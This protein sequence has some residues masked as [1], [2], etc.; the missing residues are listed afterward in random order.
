MAE[1]GSSEAFETVTIRSSDG[2]TEA[3]FV[4]GANMLCASLRHRGAEL[5]DSGQGVSAYAERGTTMGIPLLYPWANRLAGAGYEAA[6]R[7]VD[8]EPAAD[9][10][11][12]DPNGLP[13]HG[14]LPGR[15]SWR[16]QAGSVADRIV[17]GLDWPVPDLQGVFPYEHQL[18]FEAHVREAE[19]EI[20]T[21]V[22]A[23]GRDR[24][25]VAYGFHPYL[26]VPGASR[27]GFRVSLGAFRRLVLDD[28]GIPT[29][30]RVPLQRR[31][32]R[33]EQRS[34]DDGLDGLAIPPE[35]AVSAG[36]L[37]ITVT[38]D[39][40]FQFAQ[41]YAPPDHDFICFEPMTAPANALRSGDGLIILEPGEEHRSAFSIRISR[42]LA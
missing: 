3:A 42:R 29:G 27:Q 26:R 5:L 30:E 20:T 38:F 28:L 39:Y 23:S 31:T 15:L 25:P 6:D 9:L 18:R 13:I 22:R 16:V 32:F 2:S 4:P 34:L 12:H 11:P 41:V 40:G 10:I 24:V 1:M 7:R 33:L 19:L 37:A 36:G 35:F 8:L 21:T 17:A 14:V